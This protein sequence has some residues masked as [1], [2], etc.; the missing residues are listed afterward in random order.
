LVVD[1]ID[2]TASI[3]PAL[4]LTLIENGLSHQNAPRGATAFTLR[5]EQMHKGVRYAFTS[6]GIVT[7]D[8][9][10]TLGGT[11]LRYVRARLDESFLGA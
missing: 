10:R 9:T 7:A 6:P 1:G 8:A 5:A 4:F 3:P 2:P 11:G